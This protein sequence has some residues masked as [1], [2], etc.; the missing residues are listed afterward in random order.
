MK[1]E[2]IKA[3]TNCIGK[4]ITEKE[5]YDSEAEEFVFNDVDLPDFVRLHGNASAFESYRTALKYGRTNKESDQKMVL[6]VLC[7]HNYDRVNPFK[8]FRLNKAQYSA[9]HVEGEVLL[10]DGIEL[11]VMGTEQH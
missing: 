11:V 7:M 3:W 9:H 8:G 4:A 6:F 2:Q 1:D 5:E 10:P